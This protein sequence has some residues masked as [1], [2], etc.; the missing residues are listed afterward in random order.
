MEKTIEQMV[1]ERQL[2]RAEINRIINLFPQV[3]NI[4]D[5]NNEKE[6][7]K[8][9]FKDKKDYIFIKT[10]KAKFD[11]LKQ[12]VEASENLNPRNYILIQLLKERNI[13][14]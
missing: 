9:G 14:V 1:E 8:A 7:V 10:I 2:L 11:K 3:D 4:E 12:Y 5:E 6:I 13:D